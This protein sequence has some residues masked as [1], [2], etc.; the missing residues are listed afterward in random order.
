M[1]ILEM[2]EKI[3]S[4]GEPSPEDRRRPQPQRESGSGSGSRLPQL[5]PVPPPNGPG[6]I[7]KI[8]PSVVQIV[9]LKQGF[10]GGMSSAWTGSGTIIHPQGVILTN[11]HVANPRAMGMAGSDADQLAI[12][13]TERSDAPPALTWFARLVAWSAELDLAVLRIVSDMRGQP[14]G[15]LNLPA[16]PIGDSDTIDLGDRLSIF[17]YP[18]IGG[19]T[20]TYTSGSV[21]GF[22]RDENVRAARAWIKTDAT[23]AGGNSGGTAVDQDGFLVGIPTQASAGTGITPVDARPVLDTNGDGRIDQRDTP[24][25][26]GGFINGLRPVNLAIPLLEKAGM[27]IDRTRKA[28]GHPLPEPPAPL[29]APAP[30]PQPAA[31]GKFSRLLFAAQLTEDG[32]PINPAQNF[33]AGLPEI[34][35]TFEFENM[36]PAIPWSAVW[37]SGDQIVI[38]QKGNWDEGPTGRKAVRIA[39]R[40]GLPPGDYHL[41]LG[42][43]SEVVLEGRIRVQE[44]IDDSDSEVSGRLVDAVTGKGIADGMVVV[45]QPRASLRD[46]LRNRDERMVL[47]SADTGA[48]GRF[49][50]PR[51]LPKGNSYS[52]IAAGRGYQ[53]L[54]VENALRLGAGAPEKADVGD[55]RLERQ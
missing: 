45:L 5:D 43:R 27:V 48:D 30:S 2:L 52:L 1:S 46:F 54:T 20:V 50:L 3:L 13:V 39:N 36:A 53:P 22:T 19:E 40:K 35:A 49:C 41:V 34:F 33:P 23:I 37:M 28:G 14:V 11:C 31:R 21:S 17:G 7:A 38:E 4:P 29:P 15:R 8:L 24:M 51:Q 16:V 32:R 10:L 42:I 47:T 6:G 18:G 26:I 9:A 44:Q 55:I 25:A 12:A